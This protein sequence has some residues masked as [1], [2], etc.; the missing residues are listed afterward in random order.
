MAG[1]GGTVGCENL[2]LQFNRAMTWQHGL[3]CRLILP[4]IPR[5]LKHIE[6]AHEDAP[7]RDAERGRLR[8][9]R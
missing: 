3:F 8:G 4:I 1:E 5:R 9:G 2:C 6:L 7:E